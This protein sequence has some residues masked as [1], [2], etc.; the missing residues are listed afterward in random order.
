MN[1]LRRITANEA[2]D[3]LNNFLPRL[4]LNEIYD[5]VRAAVKDGYDT[6]AFDLSA[7]PAAHR[8]CVLVPLEK[9][10]YRLV[11]MAWGTASYNIFW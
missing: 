9:D 5:A 2:R 8:E 3:E 11:K 4:K 7:I 10:G 6:V 1:E